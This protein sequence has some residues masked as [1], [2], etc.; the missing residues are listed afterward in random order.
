MPSTL[1]AEARARERLEA[2]AVGVLDRGAQLGERVELGARTREL[3]VERA[4]LAL[5]HRVHVQLDVGVAPAQLRV[6]VVGRQRQL[7]AA[8]L[9]RRSCRAARARSPR[10][11]A[12]CR[13]ARGSPTVEASGTGLPPALTCMSTSTKS[14][15]CAAALDRD[16][17]R[18]LLAQSLELGVDLVGRN[19]DLLLHALELERLRQR[20][21]WAATGTRP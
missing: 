20:A 7:G 5:A 9:A 12:R 2:L 21:A 11:C 13:A 17:R 15:V 1:G 18:G 19:L 4:G 10:T 3:V 8:R 16:E 14:P 6:R